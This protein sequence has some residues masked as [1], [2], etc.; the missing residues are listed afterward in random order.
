M[1]ECNGML[2]RWVALLTLELKGNG[3]ESLCFLSASVIP[4]ITI[5]CSRLSE[6]SFSKHSMG[7]HKKTNN[8][9]CS[10]TAPR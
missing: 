4:S 1:G 5:G 6:K 3:L 2:K 7:R 10:L 8:E 9:Y